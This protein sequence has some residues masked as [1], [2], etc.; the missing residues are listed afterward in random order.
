MTE[1]DLLI[2]GLDKLQDKL[3]VLYELDELDEQ[4]KLFVLA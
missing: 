2:N 4:K 1:L 3:D